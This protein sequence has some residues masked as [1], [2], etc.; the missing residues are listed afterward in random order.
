MQI[1]KRQCGLDQ[2]QGSRR[3]S[4]YSI[5]QRRDAITKNEK[6]KK[7]RM[8]I[9]NSE[10]R[11]LTKQTCVKKNKQCYGAIHTIT[12]HNKVITNYFS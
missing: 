1:D 5:Y 10:K 9:K 7:D 8:L 4:R 2:Q 6:L 3:M 12:F 11:R